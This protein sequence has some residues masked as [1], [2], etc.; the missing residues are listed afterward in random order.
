MGDN[1]FVGEESQCHVYV[2]RDSTGWGVDIPG[3]WNG[4][5]IDYLPDGNPSATAMIANVTAKQRYPWNGLV[6]ITC[7]VSGIDE[8]AHGPDLTLMFVDPDSGNARY[9]SQFWAVRGGTKTDDV[10]VP[11]N[12]EYR[13]LWDA[14]ADLG[15]VFYSNMV[16]RVGFDARRKVQLWEGGP[17]W[18]ETNVGADEPWESGLYFWWGDAVGCRRA[19]DAW[20]ASDGST[21]N[22]SFQ[23]GGEAPYGKTADQLR[24]EGWTTE[25]GVLAPEHDSARAH[26]G[27]DWRMPTRQEL[28]DIGYNKCDWI[29]TTTNG[30]KGVVVRG[31]GDYAEAAIFLPFTGWAIE[32]H[33]DYRDAGFLWASDPRGDMPASWRLKF[34]L[35]GKKD[36]R[37][38]C[39]VGYHWDRLVT[40]PVRPVRGE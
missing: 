14:R 22:F 9:A 24:S 13:L 16:V 10:S 33:W 32:S 25:D 4:I 30:V 20:V 35:T 1:V 40:V 37:P 34:S 39:C 3:T 31:R 18:A 7:T 5:A 21:T 15:Q 23:H 2:R 12:G 26:W 8:N 28:L 29:P 11:T 6:D 17:C 36:P 27:R 38:R 19:G